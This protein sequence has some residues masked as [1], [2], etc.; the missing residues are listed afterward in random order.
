MSEYM[1]QFRADISGY[2][3]DELIDAALAARAEASCTKRHPVAF[4]DL[5]G[6]RFDASALAIAHGERRSSGPSLAALDHL[7]YVLAPHEPRRAVEQFAARLK[8]YGL[9]QV[10][11]DRYAGEWVPA[12]FRDFGIRYVNS[13]LSASEIYVEALPLWTGRRVRLIDDARLLTELRLLERKPRAGGH[14]DQIDHPRGAHDDCAVAACGALHLASVY[15]PLVISDELMDWLTVPDSGR[16]GS[17][18]RGY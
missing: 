1:G 15:S 8:T 2:L 16:V 18:T 12:A 6:G 7:E 13:E 5:S 17:Y 10:T 9:Q 4:A 11:G 14:P 3:S